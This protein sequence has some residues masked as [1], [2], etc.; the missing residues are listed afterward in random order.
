MAGNLIEDQ[1]QPEC[2]LPA[3]EAGVDRLVA[4]MRCFMLD[5]LPLSSQLLYDS[6]SAHSASSSNVNLQPEQILPIRLGI[7]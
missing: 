1:H 4:Q 2:E 3:L 5:D 6:S 7:K